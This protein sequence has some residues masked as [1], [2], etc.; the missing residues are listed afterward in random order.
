MRPIPSCPGYFASDDGRIWRGG[1]ALRSRSNGHGYLAITVSIG[2]KRQDKYVHRLVCEA[3]HGSAP[4]QHECRH[5]DG[6]RTNNS[7]ENLCWSTKLENEADK[8]IHGTLNCGE[9]QGRSVLTSVQ[10]I[11]ARYRVGRGEMVQKIAAEFGVKPPTLR[12][13]IMGRG[14]NHIPGALRPYST[15]R[16]FSDDQ[17]RAIRRLEGTKTIVA[18]AAEYGVTENAIRQILRGISYTHVLVEQLPALPKR[19]A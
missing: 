10:V 14:W 11:E 8:I 13:A 3:F 15:R 5:L 19:T 7:P 1:R 9:R 17:V 4:E 16:K 2:G 6:T 12:Y 18:I